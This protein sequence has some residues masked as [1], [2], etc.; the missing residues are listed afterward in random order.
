MRDENLETLR[1]LAGRPSA[2]A[3]EVAHHV[4]LSLDEAREALAL[5]EEEGYVAYAAAAA[6]GGEPRYTL[7]AAGFSA[8]LY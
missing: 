6:P 3:G 4:G 7:T 2:T 1:A 8:V 5:L